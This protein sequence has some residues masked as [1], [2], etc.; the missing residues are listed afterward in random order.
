MMVVTRDDFVDDE[1]GEQGQPERGEPDDQGRRDGSDH[2]SRLPEH[3]P[4]VPPG[5]RG[6]GTASPEVFRRLADDG[7]AGVGL[8]QVVHRHEPSPV[9]WVDHPDSAVRGA[10]EH[11]EMVELPVQDRPARQ[12]AEV[13]QIRPD[14]PGPQPAGARG[15]D[16]R[17]RAD[18]V[19][20]GAGQVPQL[21]EVDALAEVAEHHGQAC[22]A[23]VG[24]FHLPDVRDGPRHGEVPLLSIAWNWRARRPASDSERSTT[25]AWV[26][27]LASCATEAA[28]AP[29]SSWPVS[30]TAGW[31][32]GA[33]PA[34]KTA[35]PPASRARRPLIRR[36][37]PPGSARVSCRA[38][39]RSGVTTAGS[40]TVTVPVRPSMIAG[41]EALSSVRTTHKPTTAATTRTR[42]SR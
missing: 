11:H 13:S 42:A 19:A 3:R 26:R 21:A 28:A 25:D 40:R 39:A 6:A 41:P 27:R 34:A 18:A 29:E 17:Q 23:A 15:A 5:A 33:N 35:L 37:R 7:D 12:V 14:A 32:S 2:V 20:A 30:R 38:P 4:Q 24:M 10:L 9:G 16:H 22:R 8:A 31:V 1:C 36:D